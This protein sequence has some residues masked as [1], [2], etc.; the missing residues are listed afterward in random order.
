MSLMAGRGYPAALLSITFSRM[1][2]LRKRQQF[3]Y[4]RSA[5]V[6]LRR[7]RLHRPKTRQCRFW[8][9]LRVYPATYHD[10]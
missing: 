6:S 10:A 8:L 1:L 3:V 2:P 5:A 9:Y 4:L 7:N